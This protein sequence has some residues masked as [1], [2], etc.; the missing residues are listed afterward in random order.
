MNNIQNILSLVNSISE[1]YD[2][3]AQ[4][5]GENFNIFKVLGVQ[6]SEVRLHSRLLA[7]L[8]SPNGNHGKGAV[9]LK[10][11]CNQ[12]KIEDFVTKNA[13][14]KIERFVGYK[15][16]E[17]AT[18]GY[19]DILLTDSNGKYI[20]IENKIY[21]EDQDKQL[22]RYYNFGRPNISKLIYL[23]LDGCEPSAGSK[24]NLN[25]DEHYFCHSYKFDIIEWLEQCHKEAAN[26]AMLRES[27]V[28]YIH[29]LK[30][31][32]NQSNNH[33]MVSEI[34]KILSS[35]TE[36]IKSAIEIKN[37]INQIVDQ[38]L[39]KVLQNL[40]QFALENE[41]IFSSGEN[42]NDSGYGFYFKPKNW[43]HVKIGFEFEKSN[44]R[45]FFYGV[46]FENQKAVPEIVESI[47]SHLPTEENTYEN[48]WP[49]W[50]KFPFYDWN[51]DESIIAV[52]NGGIEN[53]IKAK[54]K[55]II[56]KLN[57]INSL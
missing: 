34:S 37:S 46:V 41:L 25:V 17:K 13:M 44:K 45:D 4:A 28:Q 36:N 18:G 19:I 9:F 1:K 8:L 21:A 7:E 12:F 47:K 2:K 24:G 57:S 6:N 10:L 20:I 48:V 49:Y 40:K 31:L 54:T 14:V 11:F 30:H 55:E 29:L 56:E 35:T 38:I 22:L 26:H 39:P 16:D 53:L 33:I 3:I 5:T 42:F 15:D 27:I 23:T 51:T 52:S 50:D 43:S 32:T